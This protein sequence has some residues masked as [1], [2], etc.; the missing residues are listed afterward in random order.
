ME[1]IKEIQTF[2]CVKKVAKITFY[3]TKQR[4]LQ[5]IIYLPEKK[6]IWTKD[7]LAWGKSRVGL[8][9]HF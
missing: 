9:P 5:S 8:P 7:I 2:I 4:T 1:K 3:Q 6:R